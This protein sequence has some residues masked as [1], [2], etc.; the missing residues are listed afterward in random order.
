MFIKDGKV[1]RNLEEQVQFLTDYHQINQGLAEWGIRI[2]GQVTSA[3]DLPV[4]YDGEFGDAYAVGYSAPYNFYI[5]TRANTTDSSDY[6]FPFGKISIAGPQGP[7]GPQGERGEPGIPAIWYAGSGVPV[8]SIAYKEGDMYLRTDGVVSRYS[9]TLGWTTVADIKGPAGPR[10]IQGIPGDRGEQGP[11]GPQGEKGDPAGIVTIAGVLSNTSQLPTPAAQNNLKVAYLIGTA[12]PYDL[13]IQVGETPVTATWRNVGPFNAAT[14]VT[15]NGIAQN[16]WDSDIKVNRTE[17]ENYLNKNTFP[18]SEGAVLGSVQLSFTENEAI[19]GSK[20][21]G[22][23]STALGQSN[24]V[25]QRCSTAVGLANIVGNP[26]G[27]VNDNSISFSAGQENRVYGKACAV[28]GAYNSQVDNKVDYSAILSGTSNK[29]TGT[30]SGSAI[31][32][33]SSNTINSSYNS[34]AAGYYNSIINGDNCVSIGGSNTVRTD[35]TILIGSGLKAETPYGSNRVL[36]GKYNAINSYAIFAV[37]NGTSEADRSNAFEI[38]PD[39]TIK[40]KKLTVASDDEH[41]LVTKNY[42]DSKAE[43]KLYSHSIHLVAGE[44][45]DSGEC[46]CYLNVYSTS[47]QPVGSWDELLYILPDGG[48]TL[49]GKYF[50][51]FGYAHYNS[52]MLLT[53]TGNIIFK[54]VPNGAS[55]QIPDVVEFTPIYVPGSTGGSNSRPT[56]DDTV[57]AL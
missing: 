36:V 8:P 11:Q 50:P 54:Y 51:A 42:V 9:D 20:S 52:A 43:S 48:V 14:L 57:T 41:C 10:G 22:K 32:C 31:L 27:G 19:K 33:G 45:M 1:Y 46:D 7:Q 29:L 47:S 53:K 49:S 2:V 6:W 37:G 13:F 39:G 12:A 55:Y 38:F 25:H 28:L 15:V 35:S 44:D 24:E 40:A 18:I 16:I 3:T 30:A 26:Q 21:Y 4:P 23:Y 56:V 17:L 5:W 34:I